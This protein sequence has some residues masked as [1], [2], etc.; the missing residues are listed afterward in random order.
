MRNER[1]LAPTHLAPRL[2]EAQR[3]RGWRGP[4]SPASQGQVK[5]GLLAP[6]GSEMMRRG[7]GW[8]ASGGATH[9]L[10][11]SM[12]PG[13]G[14]EPQCGSRAQSS[15]CAVEVTRGGDRHGSACMALRHHSAKLLVWAPG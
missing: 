14:G 15:G 1:A 9:P 6:E 11:L 10:E 5:S 13:Q 7:P 12:E 4:T 3:L 2:P 8:W